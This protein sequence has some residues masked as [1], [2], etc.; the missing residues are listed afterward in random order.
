VLRH[1]LAMP[2]MIGCNHAPNFDD[3]HPQGVQW[4]SLGSFILLAAQ[5][6]GDM[7][8]LRVFQAHSIGNY[9]ICI[10]VVLYT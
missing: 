6:V 7:P 5:Q 1:S 9:I 8:M 10:V 2:V 4:D 3:A